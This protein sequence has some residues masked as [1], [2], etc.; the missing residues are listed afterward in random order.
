MKLDSTY[1]SL[2]VT[3]SVM[4]GVFASYAALEF[5]A[6]TK[7][8]SRPVRWY[9]L[10]AGAI[11]VGTGIW[12]VHFVGMLAYSLALPV[13]LDTG[14]TIASWIAPVLLSASAFALIQHKKTGPVRFVM[15]AILLGVAIAGMHYL[16][17]FALL[18]T[19]PITYSPWRVTLSV[20]IAI[21]LSGAAL[22]AMQ[23][24][25]HPGN[26]FNWKN[27]VLVSV[28]LGTAIFLMH[29]TGMWAA[30]FPG[31]SANPIA[32]GLDAQFLPTIAAVSSIGLLFIATS[33]A[34]LHRRKIEQERTTE[35]DTLT[36]L[37]NRHFL[38]K[39]FPEIA[40]EAKANGVSIHLAV[41]DLDSFKLVNDTMG[42]EAG[43][44]VL[45]IAARRIEQCMRK[46]DLV[47]RV[48]GDKFL[49]VLVGTEEACL[50]DTMQ[51]VI[52]AL[53]A[54]MHVGN[55]LT[56]ISASIG[57][58]RHTDGQHLESLLM[59]ADT[60]MY[61][62]KKQGRNIWEHFSIHMDEERMAAAEIHKRLRRAFQRNEFQL[63]Y[64]P[65]YAC[66]S[67]RLVGVEALVRWLDPERG[68]R[69]PREFIGIAERTGLIGSLGNWV[70]DEAC[71]Q[72]RS[73]SKQGCNVPVAI[74]VSA[75]QIRGEEMT[76]R[77]CETL[78]KHNVSAE[79]LTLEITESVA[80]EDPGKAMQIFESLKRCGVS[81][82]ID[83]FGTGYSSLAYLK[84]FPATELKIDRAFVQ[85]IA[86]NSQ[87]L[88]L[89]KAMVAMGHALEMRVVAEGVENERTA[90]LLEMLGC[91][92]L[93]GNHL[94]LPIDA[95]SIP[96][97]MHSSA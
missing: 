89:V 53:N 27:K 51:R 61:F 71:R 85:D 46:S 44:A 52:S 92:V 76:S 79:Y 41:V 39:K 4:I 62:A 29:Y 24:A 18:T 28:F 40:D 3:V 55:E 13:G 26:P 36:K 64:Q 19:S 32:G 77:V 7:T 6:R 56:T 8:A 93:Q 96:P 12:S 42:H 58:A 35:R 90:E 94:G 50:K 67:R 54:P 65:K 84:R 47:V 78:I 59:H 86:R 74:N 68:M 48:G 25:A 38:H 9:W 75:L 88:E 97:L 91:D 82:S 23:R 20:V 72:I 17:M 45:V 60:A 73:W 30:S 11:V 16:G 14:L 34:Y 10:G 33:I 80:I 63:L 15:S 81:I 31:A 22:H 70:L 21:V 83:D 49:V 37:K 1:S 2:L 66:G 5:A 95:D 87:S 43:D 57:V 69:L